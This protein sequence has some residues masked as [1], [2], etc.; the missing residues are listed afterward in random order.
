MRGLWSK[1]YIDLESLAALIE[2]LKVGV[3]VIPRLLRVSLQGSV[4]YA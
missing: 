4:G 2:A 1:D 3:L